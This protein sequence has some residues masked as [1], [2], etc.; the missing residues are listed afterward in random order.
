VGADNPSPDVEY[1]YSGSISCM[2]ETPMYSAQ[3]FHRR[4]IPLEVCCRCGPLIRVVVSPTES[5]GA[6][7]AIKRAPIEDCGG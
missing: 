5:K 4:C 6:N 7:R 3:A 1:F 2:C